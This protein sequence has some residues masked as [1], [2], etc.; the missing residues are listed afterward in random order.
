MLQT[1]IQR[2][3]KELFMNQ[4]FCGNDCEHCRKTHQHSCPGCKEGGIFLSG[5]CPIMDCAR[6]KGVEHCCDCQFQ[7]NCHT[8]PRRDNLY[9][10]TRKS[11]ACTGIGKWLTLM[12]IFRI[13][14]TIFSFAGDHVVKEKWAELCS[15]II[16]LL[17]LGVMIGVLLVMKHYHEQY[18]TAARW[19][20][21]GAAVELVPMIARLFF[22]V[23]SDTG[24]VMLLNC[25]C[26]VL[27]VVGMCRFWATNSELL[28]PLDK[29]RSEQWEKLGGWYIL[30]NGAILLSLLL[31][32]TQIVALLFVMM[33][34][35]GIGV[36]GLVVVNFVE[37]VMLFQTGAYLKSLRAK[38][39]AGK[40]E[41]TT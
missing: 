31:G 2:L 25:A 13:L 21:L 11:T 32:M 17:C 8:H 16:S 1:E 12:G 7:E 33:F 4:T 28:N 19:L 18:Q 30:F 14:E 34:L 23:P 36:F 20:T 40:S 5:D 41:Y 37:V 15:A 39:E 26:V 3:I 24:W 38:V 10:C 35:L 6:S 29:K 27:M 9:G 22:D